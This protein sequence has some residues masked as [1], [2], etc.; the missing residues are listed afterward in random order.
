MFCQRAKLGSMSPS[1]FNFYQPLTTIMPRIA[2]SSHVSWHTLPPHW[3]LEMIK[4]G[5]SC[6]FQGCYREKFCITHWGGPNDLYGPF[7][8]WDSKYLGLE[9]AEGFLAAGLS[10][11]FVEIVICCP[12][13][14]MCC[15]LLNTAEHYLNFGSM[16]G[17]AWI[18][19]TPLSNPLCGYGHVVLRL[20]GLE[21]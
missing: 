19:H 5:L 10:K 14:K 8:F 18:N 4:R 1:T 17:F 21:V 7:H 20:L 3:W 16:S 11:I 13:H 6:F 9:T 2:V 12:F 15:Q